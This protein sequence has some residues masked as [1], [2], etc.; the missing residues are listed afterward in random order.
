MDN[1]TFKALERIISKLFKPTLSPEML[2]D[3]EAVEAWLKFNS[4]F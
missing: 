3:I 2:A 4:E 1:E